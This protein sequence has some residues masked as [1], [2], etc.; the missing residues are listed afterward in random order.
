MM[1]EKSLNEEIDQLKDLKVLTETYETIAASAMRRIRESVFKNREFHSGLIDIFQ[2]VK[3]VYHHELVGLSARQKASVVRVFPLIDPNKRTVFV[4]LSSNAGLYGEIVSKTFSLFM[5]EYRRQNPVPDVLVVGRVGQRLFEEAFPGALFTYFEAPDT[6]IDLSAL[7]QIVGYLKQY[8][9]VI[10]FY[11]VFKNIL[12]Q[13][14]ISTDI[15]GEVASSEENNSGKE[16]VSYLF[17]PSLETVAIFFE[18]EIFA[19]LVEQAFHEWRLAKVA[20]RFVLM[21]RASLNIDQSLKNTLT[22]IRR[23]SHRSANKQLINSLSG[24][25]LWGATLGRENLFHR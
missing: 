18:T 4:L 2:E 9:R 11:G 6:D 7:N 20:N 17:E 5:N 15:S 3:R 23:I 25:S 10:V 13:S 12:N 14:A 21:D 19:S 8:E 24:A 16:K 1:H 22:L